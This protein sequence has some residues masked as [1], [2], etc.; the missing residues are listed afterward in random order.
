MKSYQQLN[1]HDVSHMHLEKQSRWDDVLK[2]KQTGKLEIDKLDQIS[3]SMLETNKDYL[4]F[5]LQFILFFAKQELPFRG[6]FE[7]DTESNRGTSRS[8]SSYRL[9]HHPLDINIL[10]LRNEVARIQ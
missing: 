4:K 10:L 9:L 5:I 6:K 7:L 2:R 8:T 1:K 3:T